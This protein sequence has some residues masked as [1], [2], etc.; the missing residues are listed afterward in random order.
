MGGFIKI[1]LREGVDVVPIYFFGNARET[2][3]PK[4]STSGTYAR[5]TIGKPATTTQPEV[6]AGDENATQ[7]REARK[8]SKDARLSERTVSHAELLDGILAR[9]QLC[10]DDAEGGEHREAA[11]VQLPGAHLVV[12]LPPC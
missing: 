11:V 3:V 12:I 9:Q 8:L 2:E 5:G 6:A 7:W 10:R 1:A 4:R